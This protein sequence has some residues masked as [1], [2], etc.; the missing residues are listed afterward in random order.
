MSD[1]CSRWASLVDAEA[2]GETLSKSDRAFVREHVRTCDLCRAEAEVWGALEG[3][4]DEPSEHESIQPPAPAP[5]PAPPPA[6]APA[7]LSPH[8]RLTAGRA[9]L[10]VA[11]CAGR[12]GTPRSSR[13]RARCCCRASRFAP[14][15]AQ[16]RVPRAAR[17]LRADS[18]CVRSESGCAL[19]GFARLRCDARARERRRDRARWTRGRGRRAARSRHRALRTWRVGVPRHRAGSACVRGEGQHGARLRHRRK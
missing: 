3:L 7:V 18:V 12:N 5:A 15:E 9:G 8:R 16:S 10:A 2:V 19:E 1:S 4:V 14:L 13:G 17:E 11:T 6:S